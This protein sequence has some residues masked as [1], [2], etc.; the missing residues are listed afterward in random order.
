MKLYF[1]N[2]YRYMILADNKS[3][4]EFIEEIQISIPANSFIK[5]ISYHG[6][7]NIEHKNTNVNLSTYRY[8]SSVGLLNRIKQNNQQTEPLI[9]KTITH[10]S[11]IDC[12]NLLNIMPV[13]FYLQYHYDH[14]IY[15]F[16]FSEPVFINT[17]RFDYIFYK[18]QD[19]F[20]DEKIYKYFF[21]FMDECD[22]DKEIANTKLK[23]GYLVCKNN[24][25]TNSEYYIDS[26]ELDKNYFSVEK[27]LDNTIIEL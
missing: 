26:A 19:I 9:S 20:N 15:F 23:N 10:I 16:M 17:F 21:N 13:I 5:N 11:I 8:L 27:Y 22:Y 24:K 6:N 2:C 12:D 4:K 3:Q 1:E 7:K 18:P 25:I 14:T